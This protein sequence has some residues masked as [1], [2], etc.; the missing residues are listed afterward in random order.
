MVELSLGTILQQFPDLLVQLL[1]FIA[2]RTVFNAIA[3]SSK[4]IH[5]QSKL[6]LPPWP[7]NFKLSNFITVG[8]EMPAPMFSPDGRKIMYV[9]HYDMNSISIID[10]R[11][12]LLL[13]RRRQG[14]ITTR[15]M[16]HNNIETILSVQ[17]SVDGKFVVTCVGPSTHQN[18]LRLWDNTTTGNYELLQDWD[19]NDEIVDVISKF[20]TPLFSISQ[21]SKFVVVLKGR[22]VLLKDIQQEGKTIQ[23]VL[24]PDNYVMGKQI[25]FSNRMNS[26]SCHD[27]SIFIR[28]EEQKDLLSIATNI[29]T[30]IY[31][32]CPY[33]NLA[34]TGNNIQSLI[35]ISNE[36]Y[37]GNFAL[38]SDHSLLAICTPRSRKVLIWSVVDNNNNDD[39]DEYN[40]KR[41]TSKITIPGRFVNGSVYFTPDDQYL[42][43]ETVNSGLR[44]WSTVEN[45]FN[46]KSSTVTVDYY[47]G[48]SNRYSKNNANHLTVIGFSPADNHRLLLRDAQLNTCLTSYCRMMTHQ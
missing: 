42:V 15:W 12:G 16:T 25:I 5:A 34:N 6:Y 29:N 39:A 48:N 47:H 45:A 1:P 19:I 33:N 41:L 46:C 36:S 30:F 8:E 28:G 7:L 4:S 31:L 24:L 37:L 44:F 32:W 27:V 17:F 22:H 20:S 38:T 18:Y 14:D 26:S 9:N 2:D 3:S 11:R 21:C 23:S 40:R 13:R 35:T 43:L 10:Q